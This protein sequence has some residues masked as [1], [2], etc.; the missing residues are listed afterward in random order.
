[1]SPQKKAIELILDHIENKL[2]YRLETTGLPVGGG[3]SAEAQAAKDNGATLDKQR[4]TITYKQRQDRTLPLLILSKN[5]IQGV[6]ME[7]LFNIGNLIS[8]ATEL[9]QDDSVQLLSASVSTDA[10]PVGKVGD[11][12]IYSMVVDVRIAF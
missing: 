2:G 8:K 5:K 3:L 12:W 9:P 10:A 1:M 7:Q 4:H 6:A 11:Y